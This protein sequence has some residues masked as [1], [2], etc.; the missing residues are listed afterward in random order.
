[1]KK[2]LLIL[3]SGLL[4][5]VFSQPLAAGA[6][7]DESSTPAETVLKAKCP[8]KAAVVLETAK[9][10]NFLEYHYYHLQAQPGTVAV[11]SAVNGLLAEARI[12]EGSLVF[13]GQEIL[14]IETISAEELKKLEADAAAK[15]K[16]WTNR[17]NWKEKSAKA[18]QA[19][20]KSYQ[21]AL[22]LLEEK[23]VSSR[24]P[25]VSP[26]TGT[27]HFVQDLGSSVVVDAVLLEIAN[28][29]RVV[30][31]LAPGGAEGD[32]F[33]VGQKYNGV[34]EN[35]QGLAEVIA[36]SDGQVTFVVDNAS[37]AL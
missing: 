33:A 32:A 31:T 21:E 13:V 14:A 27:V 25:I 6:A 3:W 22:A 1:M 5:C 23:K 35:F 9:A 26:A 18:I 4:L 10:E 16:I 17:L 37:G 28:P 2:L 8:K 29:G 7:A 12:G 19:A 34:A 15:K 11:K 20:E 30:Y 36:V 24:Q